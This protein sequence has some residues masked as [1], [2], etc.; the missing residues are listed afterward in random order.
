MLLA[1]PMR[2]ANPEMAGKAYDFL[3]DEVR[4][5][6]WCTIKAFIRRGG[7]YYSRTVGQHSWNAKMMQPAVNFM[8]SAWDELLLEEK[9][10][11]ETALA[12]ILSA[13]D[14]TLEDVKGIRLLA[15]FSP[16]KLTK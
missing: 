9:A 10:A 6:H 8:S 5:W 7:K 16:T 13:L 1:A 11:S 14:G 2:K 15:H 4:S 12:K 3:N